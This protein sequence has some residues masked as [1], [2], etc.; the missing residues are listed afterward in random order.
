MFFDRFFNRFFNTLDNNEILI[1][2]SEAQQQLDLV[3]IN[4]KT[5]FYKYSYFLMWISTFLLSAY[6]FYLRKSL[7]HNHNLFFKIK[8]DN[9]KLLYINNKFK[10]IF[11]KINEISKMEDRTAKKICL[12]KNLFVQNKI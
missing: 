5:D 9:D 7:K 1:F 3:L 12:I 11:E 6:V 2:N 4:Y 10:K 8:K